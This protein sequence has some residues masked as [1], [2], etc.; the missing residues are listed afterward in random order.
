MGRNKSRVSW[1]KRIWPDEETSTSSWTDP[2]ASPKGLRLDSPYVDDE[3]AGETGVDPFVK[4]PT[5]R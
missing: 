5:W 2:L 3:H 4:K 1:A